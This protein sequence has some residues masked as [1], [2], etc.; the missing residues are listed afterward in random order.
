MLFAAPGSQNVIE[1]VK[2]TSL[3]EKRISNSA[4]RDTIGAAAQSPPEKIITTHMVSSSSGPDKA[5]CKVTRKLSELSPSLS[6]NL[7]GFGCLNT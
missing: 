2:H 6:M 7:R 3:K 5:T 4:G 1:Y